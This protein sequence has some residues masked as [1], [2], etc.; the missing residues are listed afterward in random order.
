MECTIESADGGCV[1]GRVQQQSSVVAKQV[2]RRRVWA[3]GAQ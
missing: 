2:H 1:D 3:E